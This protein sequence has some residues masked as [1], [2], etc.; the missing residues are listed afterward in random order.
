MESVPHPLLWQLHF[1][2]VDSL[3]F[4]NVTDYREHV[5]AD[6]FIVS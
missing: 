2:A 5:T 3:M 4:E 1:S 6:V